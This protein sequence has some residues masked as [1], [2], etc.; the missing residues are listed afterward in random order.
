MTKIQN[1]GQTLDRVMAGQSQ[2]IIATYGHC[3]RIEGK[4][5]AKWKQAGFDLIKPE[6]SGYRMRS[7]RKSVFVFDQN[8]FEQSV[9]A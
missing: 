5:I 6:G 7:G 2:I 9:T 3:T 1:F 4:H 8:V